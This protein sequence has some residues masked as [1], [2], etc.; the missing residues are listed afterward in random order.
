MHPPPWTDHHQNNHPQQTPAPAPPRARMMM[1]IM[2]MIMF[3]SYTDYEDHHHYD[4]CILQ[5][6]WSLSTIYDAANFVTKGR[7]DQWIRCVGLVELL[8]I[9]TSSCGSL[10]AHY[11]HLKELLSELTKTSPPQPSQLTC[12]CWL[13]HGALIVT[14]FYPTPRI[15]L[16]VRPLVTFFTPS[17]VLDAPGVL[18]ASVRSWG[19]SSD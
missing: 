14:V 5:R 17:G 4:E 6:W 11:H 1:I 19:P 10:L 8:K 16:S 18:D 9:S 3:V 2:T 12:F 13:R 7:T 15:A